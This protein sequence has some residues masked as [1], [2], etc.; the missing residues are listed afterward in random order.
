MST[1]SITPPEAKRRPTQGERSSRARRAPTRIAINL[2]TD[3]PQN[4]S[5]AHWFWTRVIPEI[6]TRLRDDEEL[7]LIVSPTSRPHHDDYGPN[8]K[9]I[10]FPWSN[11]RRSL[12]TLSEH[13]YSPVRLPLSHIDVLS[14]LMAPVINPT[15]G[16]VIHIKTMHAFTEPASLSPAVRLYRK[17]S[18]PRS[19]RIA[20]AIIINSESLRS[21]IEN[22]L[23]VDPGKLRL[24]YEAVDHDL[25]KPSG[26]EQARR[27]LASYGVTK[28]FVLFVSSLWPYKNCMG[29][30]RA[31]ALVR[32][33]LCGRQLAIVGGGKDEKH[34]AELRS[35]VGALGIGEDVIFVG[36]IPLE[37]TARF[38]Q[39]ADALVYPSFNE[40]FGLPLLEA[41]AC[42]CPVVTSNV[43]SMP[44]IAGGAAALCDPG[45]PASIA[46]AMM[47]ALGARGAQLKQAGLDRAGQFTWGST[48]AQTLDVYREVAAL[49][50]SRADRAAR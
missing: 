42:G 32:P 19:A 31:W 16:V 30:L 47:D 14:T 33:Q 41:M 3:D 40:T 36:G 21:E 12:R 4:P 7:H 46:N 45:E 26:P 1:T 17:M 13:V 10:T 6:V 8:V 28:P 48:A 9:Y 50:R 20:D 2:L 27:D 44:E 22:Y 49:R 43:S 35:L 34:M 18:Y 24:I 11:E 5:G 38:Y 23:D 25:F 15:W 39:A 29:L 37:K